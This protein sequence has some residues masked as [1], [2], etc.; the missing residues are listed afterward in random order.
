MSGVEKSTENKYGSQI[1]TNQLKASKSNFIFEFASEIERVKIPTGKLA[2]AI[3]FKG[4]IEVKKVLSKTL[5]KD[6]PITKS[7]DIRNLVTKEIIRKVG[8]DLSVKTTKHLLP[9]NLGE[10]YRLFEDFLFSGDETNF[11]K[12]LNDFYITTKKGIIVSGDIEIDYGV[13][14]I[15]IML[16]LKKRIKWK[17]SIYIF[18]LTIPIINKSIKVKIKGYEI[19]FS[20][21][22][23]ALIDVGVSFDLLKM[24][25]SQ[26]VKRNVLPASSLSYYKEYSKSIFEIIMDIVSLAR[27]RF[28]LIG[29]FGG[30]LAAIGITMAIIGLSYAMFDE[31]DKAHSRGEKEA[32]LLAYSNAFIAR[33]LW[34]PSILKIKT[35]KIITTRSKLYEYYDNLKCCDIFVNKKKFE[36]QHLLGLNKANQ[37][38]IEF[39][40]ISDH[41]ILLGFILPAIRNVDIRHYEN[42]VNYN[43]ENNVKLVWKNFYLGYFKL[44]KNF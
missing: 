24:M 6:I 5:H 7:E 37:L 35:D 9:F 17:L 30:L 20:F 38:S 25:I 26:A 19:D 4:Y 32:R 41:D 11:I 29:S 40:K 8:K 1:L 28:A 16:K 23:E 22:G 18:L 2:L 12:N 14:E 43:T 31:I 39:Y 42:I 21:I 3:R 33:L 27:L 36:K 13:P 34:S 44:L 15:D 10:F